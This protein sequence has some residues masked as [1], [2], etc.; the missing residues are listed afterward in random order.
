MLTNPVQTRTPV[1]TTVS[2]SEYR[3][4][5]RRW[6]ERARAGE[7]VVVT[8]HGVPSVRISSA[9]GETLLDRLEREGLVRRARPRRPIEEVRPLEARPGD[10]AQQVSDDRER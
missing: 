9:D 6:H 4:D 7:E 3:A 1:G 10:S 2:V 8:E 5:M